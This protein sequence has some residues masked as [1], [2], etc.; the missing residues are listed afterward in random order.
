[1]TGRWA[2]RLKV[3]ATGAVVV[4][5]LYLADTFWSRFQGLQFRTT[6]PTGSGLLLRPCSSVHTF[7]MRFPIDILFLDREQVVLEIRR[8]VPPWRLAVPNTPGCHQVL[9]VASGQSLPAIGDRLVRDGGPSAMAEL[10][11]D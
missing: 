8:S 4:S 7:W 3:E 11:P 2:G 1:M 5:R 6:L 10:P 9:E